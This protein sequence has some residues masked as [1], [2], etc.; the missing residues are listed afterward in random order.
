MKNAEA[1]EFMMRR[2]AWC[3]QQFGEHLALATQG[4]GSADAKAL[5]ELPSS[6]P[7]ETIID[8]LMDQADPTQQKKFTPWLVREYAAGRLLLEDLVTAN[9]TLTLFQPYAPRLKTEPRNIQ[10]YGHRA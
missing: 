4:D 1:K 2:R 8:L 7:V 9:E 5:R 3:L 10:R 6:H